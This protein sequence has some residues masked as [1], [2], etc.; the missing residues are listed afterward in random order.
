[1]V[2]KQA[3]NIANEMHARPFGPKKGLEGNK[4]QKPGLAMDEDMYT[5]SF[6]KV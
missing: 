5:H 1:M 6:T 4:K 3:E 2:F